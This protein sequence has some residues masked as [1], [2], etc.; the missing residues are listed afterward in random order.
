METLNI[1]PNTET[2]HKY[3]LKLLNN[4]FKVYC[5]KQEEEITYIFFEKNNNIGNCQSELFSGL[6]F[7][8]VH[9]PNRVCGTGYGLDK[10][11]HNPTIKDA[12]ETFIN[13]PPW[14]SSSDMEHIKKYASWEDYKNFPQNCLTYIKVEMV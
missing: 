7:S 2:L 3:I 13:K 14:A 1:K 8:T 10:E 6:K 4:G 12:E 5:N 9:K 11:I